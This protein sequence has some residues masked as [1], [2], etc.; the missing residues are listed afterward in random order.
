MSVNNLKEHGITLKDAKIEAKKL[1]GYLPK[2]GYST[3]IKSGYNPSGYRYEV[4]LVN[5]GGSFHL[6]TWTSVNII[7]EEEH[8]R[9][10]TFETK[11]ESTVEFVRVSVKDKNG[12]FTSWKTFNRSDEAFEYLKEIFLI[13]EL[14]LKPLTFI[15]MVLQ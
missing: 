13:R 9:M 3:C 2:P 10:F 12:N 8:N 11:I 7:T 15:G 6:H 5:Y 1:N 4:N 14:L